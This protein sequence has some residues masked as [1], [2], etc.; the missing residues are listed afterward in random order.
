MNNKAK[1]LIILVVT[2]VAVGGVTLVVSQVLSQQPPIRTQGE[3]TP[4]T[5]EKAKEIKEQKTAGRLV[6]T[7]AIPLFPR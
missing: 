3:S 6:L 5:P 7:P 4:F 1:M 2:L